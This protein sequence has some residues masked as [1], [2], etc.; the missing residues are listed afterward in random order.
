MTA[1]CDVRHEHTNIQNVQN[2]LQYYN[3]D[4]NIHFILKRKKQCVLKY[5][6]DATFNYAYGAQR[7]MRQ[8]RKSMRIL[9]PAKN[10]C[11][12]RHWTRQLVYDTALLAFIHIVHRRFDSKMSS[13]STIK[14]INENYTL[15]RTRQYLSY[16]LNIYLHEILGFAPTIPTTISFFFLIYFHC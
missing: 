3:T 9:M 1:R 2:I 12:R 6:L 7:H 4:Y 11:F 16:L 13:S 10:A 15:A 14:F 5:L 8:G